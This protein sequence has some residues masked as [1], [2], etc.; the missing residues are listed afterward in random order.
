MRV[1]PNRDTAMRYKLTELQL[2][3]NKQVKDAR[4]LLDLLNEHCQA[5]EYHHTNITMSFTRAN[6]GTA[7]LTRNTFTVPIHA[8]NKGDTYL[9]Y[10]VIHEFTHCLG[11]GHLHDDNFKWKE[12]QLLDLF[13]IQIDYARAYPRALYANGEVVY[14]K[15]PSKR[16]I[17]KHEHVYSIMKVVN[18]KQKFYCHYC[19]KVKPD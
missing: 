1:A 11:Y 19:H 7:K 6:R 4:A 18:G 16:M 10:Y 14:S 12:K 5:N 2:A 15:T 17:P 13:D 8:I 3:G 9:F